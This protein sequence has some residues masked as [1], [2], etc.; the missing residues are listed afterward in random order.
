M[1]LRKIYSL[2]LI[3]I[4]GLAATARAEYP[5]TIRATI[6]HGVLSGP[7][8]ERIDGCKDLQELV[9]TDSIPLVKEKQHPRIKV[10][11]IASL[12]G[13]A[14]WRIHREESVSCLFDENK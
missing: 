11:S 6:S 2:A 13:E 1:P 3:A 9:I 14:I 10:L 7:A 12:L 4:L 5:P 8:I